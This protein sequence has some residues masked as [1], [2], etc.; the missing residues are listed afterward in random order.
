MIT[1]RQI[2]SWLS[3]TPFTSLF[4][5][6]KETPKEL[7]LEYRRLYQIEDIDKES[8][9]RYLNSYCTQAYAQA[10]LEWL[11]NNIFHRDHR[12]IETDLEGAFLFRTRRYDELLHVSEVAA[13]QYLEDYANSMHSTFAID[14]AA[15]RAK[16]HELTVPVLVHSSIRKIQG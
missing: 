16:K 6:Q 12:I 5:I 2:L 1:R 14:A 4:A 13:H 7:H 15:I 8:G 9:E 11:N 10:H 3:L